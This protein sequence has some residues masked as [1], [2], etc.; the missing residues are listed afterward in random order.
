MMALAGTAFAGLAMSGLATK[1]AAAQATITDADIL[2]F[3]L[4]LEYL[5]SAV[6]HARHLWPDPSTSW[7]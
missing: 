3:A 4:N 5:E 6:L 2:N 7:V 1:E